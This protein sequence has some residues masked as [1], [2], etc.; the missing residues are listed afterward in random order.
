VWFSKPRKRFAI[1]FQGPENFRA[2]PRN[3][4]FIP[5]VLL[6][7]FIHLPGIGPTTEQ[8]LWREGL[9]D[10]R[11]LVERGGEVL[12]GARAELA[13]RAAAESLVRFER[14]DWKWFDA[15]LP[16]EAKWRAFGELGQRALY[17]DIETDGGFGAE[18][19]TVIGAYDGLT[20]HTFVAERDLDAARE[21]IEGFPLVVT[22]NGAAFDMPLI[23][24]RFPYNLFNHIHV[25]L[26]FPLHRLGLRG[27][28]KMVEQLVGI[29]RGPLA[30]GL[31][32]WDAVRLWREWQEG[33]ARSLEVLLAYNREDIVN[34]APLMRLAYDRLQGCLAV[35]GRVPGDGN[36]ACQSAHHT[37]VSARRI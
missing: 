7:T 16:A 32:G 10:W 3:P 18:A 15:A 6:Q 4:W 9:G 27:G 8:R 36:R 22:Y 11:A 20:A 13:R 37:V 35:P 30:Q 25:D 29:E 1:I 5:R 26:R 19:I 14:G 12:H 24:Q 28:L 2:I 33:S 23:R 17:V 21:Y 34:L 31:D